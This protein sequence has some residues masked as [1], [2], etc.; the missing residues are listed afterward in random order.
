LDAQKIV[1][2]TV[3][4]I[5]VEITDLNAVQQIMDNFKSIQF[6]KG[7]SSKNENGFAP[8]SNSMIPTVI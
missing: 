5:K 1:I 7:K 8:L 4:G 2:I 6:E 3:D